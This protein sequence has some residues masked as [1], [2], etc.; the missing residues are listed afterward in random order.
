MFTHYVLCTVA[1]I[2]YI[3]LKKDSQK[4]KRVLNKSCFSTIPGAN[5]TERIYLAPKNQLNNVHITMKNNKKQVV[6]S[7]DVIKEQIILRLRRSVNV[8]DSSQ[9][10]QNSQNNFVDVLYTT[11]SIEKNV[12]IL[13]DLD[14]DVVD[15]PEAKF[16]NKKSKNTGSTKPNYILVDGEIDY[17]NI[18]YKKVKGLWLD[19]Q[20]KCDRFYRSST[21]K[22]DVK[23]NALLLVIIIIIF[24]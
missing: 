12:S 9:E 10:H 16:V 19:G 4:Y 1:D 17:R 11:K 21:N 8:T 18:K 15:M 6:F 7:Q 3:N 22:K 2:V 5:S 13:T 20:C 14:A 24:S 23:Q